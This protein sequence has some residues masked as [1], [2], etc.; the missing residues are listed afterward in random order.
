[1]A[2]FFNVLKSKQALSSANLQRTNLSGAN[3]TKSYLK[4]VDLSGANMEYV[5]FSEVQY[6]DYETLI[7]CNSL[8]ECRGLPEI[9]ITKTKQEKPN[10]FEKNFDAKN[11]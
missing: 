6:L 10:I 8:F 4:G 5:N 9:Y 11:W 2:L 1:M 7:K 3:F